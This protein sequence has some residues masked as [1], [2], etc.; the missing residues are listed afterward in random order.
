MI[1]LA[2]GMLFILVNFS[3]IEIGDFSLNILPEF[4]GY[5]FVLSAVDK[6]SK[7]S[8]Y[9][10]GMSGVLYLLTIYKIA[11]YFVL[12]LGWNKNMLATIFFYLGIVATIVSLIVQFRICCGIDE[13]AYD[14]DVRVG[15]SKI[16]LF[17]RIHV[18]LTIFS[19]IDNI[20]YIF[21]DYRNSQQIIPGISRPIFKL[22]NGLPDTITNAMN[23][24]GGFAIVLS[25]I[26]NILLVIFLFDVCTGYDKIM[27][28]RSGRTDED[29]Y[30][31]FED[32]WKNNKVK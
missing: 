14:D 11:D 27:A 18:V 30:R 16:F 15:T 22:L 8:T 32:D 31:E 20:Y 1:K 25:I 9:F 24:V 5:L 3:P 7:K 19:Y 6:L 12:M 21:D 10:K 2:I 17:F 4:V 13:I 28:E 29:K 26:V 23:S